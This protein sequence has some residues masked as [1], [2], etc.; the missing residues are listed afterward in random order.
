MLISNAKKSSRFYKSQE[1][2]RIQKQLPNYVWRWQKKKKT[3]FIHLVWGGRR[4][5][6]G[7]GRKS[8]SPFMPFRPNFSQ[9]L[10]FSKVAAVFSIPTSQK[11][12]KV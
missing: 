8:L 6:G 2:F 10:S 4:R 12:F 11:P 5:Y 9:N 3:V 7:V 1:H